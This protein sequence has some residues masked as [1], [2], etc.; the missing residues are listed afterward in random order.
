ME[1]FRIAVA[2]VAS[3]VLA[4]VAPLPCWADESGASAWLPGQYAS[5][6][7]V[8]GDPGFSLETIYYHR[9][10]TASASLTF[11]VGARIT[12]GL[13]IKEQYLFLTP[14]YTFADPFLHGQLSLSVTF[15]PGRMDSSVT[16]TLTGPGGNS[17][18]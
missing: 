14:S 6:A 15:A 1:K 11:S 8:P 12:A 13:D 16:A 5:F 18:T 17:L 4:C 2:I 9:H 7:A 3:Q 10:A